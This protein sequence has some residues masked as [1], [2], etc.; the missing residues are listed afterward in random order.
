MA[1]KKALGKGQ[2]QFVALIHRID[3]IQED[4]YAKISPE[5]DPN[6]YNSPRTAAQQRQ[7]DR[8]YRGEWREI[9]EATRS[10]IRSTLALPEKEANVFYDEIA[11]ILSVLSDGMSP[12]MS[13]YYQTD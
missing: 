11:H 8:M 5:S 3:E 4:V 7:V 12:D 13:D 9:R 6:K 1:T 2:A 10:A